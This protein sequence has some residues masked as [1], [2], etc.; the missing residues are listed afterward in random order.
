VEDDFSVIFITESE[1]RD[2]F[3]RKAELGTRRQ[4]VKTPV[5]MPVGTSASVKAMSPRDL[6]E[7][8]AQVVLANT[9]HL[10]L[11]PGDDLIRRAGGIGEFMGVKCPTLTDSGGFQVFSLSSLRTVDD[12]GITFR[13]HIDGSEHR[14]TPEKVMN[15]QKNLGADIVMALDQCPELPAEDED[16][17]RAMRRTTDWAKKCREVELNRHQS[18]FGIIQGGVN[19]H[20]R[21]QHAEEIQSLDFDGNALG[22]LSVGEPKEDMFR[23][24]REVAPQLEENKPRYLMGVGSPDAIIEAV[25]WGMD[26]F[27][28]VYPTRIARHGTAM[29]HDGTLPVR[30]AQFAEDF[31]PIDEE[32]DCYVC[33]N[34]TRAYIRHL[35]KADELLAFHLM[36]FHN[37]HFM[38]ELMRQIRDS[39]DRD[40][41]MSWR[42]QF[43]RRYYDRQPPE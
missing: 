1:A 2:S 4:V 10:Y 13:S 23:V 40:E 9:Y 26:M 33:R 18:L 31:K 17:K 11:R 15:I 30:N 16:M 38:M 29:T 35:I 28:S 27:D 24:L 34:F 8:G 36:T 6:E 3:A 21:K 25:R 20:L 42:K 37:L 22:G 5:F 41:F 19:V 14:F 32:C 7:V 12:E 43:W 39:I